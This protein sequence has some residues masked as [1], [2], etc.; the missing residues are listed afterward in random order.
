[1]FTSHFVGSLLDFN[2]LL[3]SIFIPYLSHQSAFKVKCVAIDVTP[4][5]LWYEFLMSVCEGGFHGVGCS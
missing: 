3:A 4:W 5:A 1:M 2:Y